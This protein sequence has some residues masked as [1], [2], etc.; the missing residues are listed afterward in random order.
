MADALVPHGLRLIV[1]IGLTILLGLLFFSHQSPLLLLSTTG[2]SSVTSIV[3]NRKPAVLS[4]SSADNRMRSDQP[5]D[6]C[7]GLVWDNATHD[8]PLSGDD[9]RSMAPKSPVIEDNRT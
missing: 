3:S 4:C 5:M 2:G 1:S 9:H 6:E 8:D 7:L